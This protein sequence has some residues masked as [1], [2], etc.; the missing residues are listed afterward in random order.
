MLSVTLPEEG[1][2]SLENR[3]PSPIL[4]SGVQHVQKFNRTAVDKVYIFLAVYRIESKNVD[5]VL[6]VNV[7]YVTEGGPPMDSTTL[8]TIERQYLTAASSLHIID[9]NLFA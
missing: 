7:P 9:F 5:L 1:T 6:S 8:G 2:S 3:T 4:L